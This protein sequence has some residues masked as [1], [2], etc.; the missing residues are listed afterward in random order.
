MELGSVYMRVMVPGFIAMFI[1][2]VIA[3][4]PRDA[5]DTRTPMKINLGVSM[6]NVLG[7]YLL[8]FG[9]GPF[10]TMG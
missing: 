1:S 2:L 4:G 10:P 8:I 3:A 5:G 9:P 7:N 6:L